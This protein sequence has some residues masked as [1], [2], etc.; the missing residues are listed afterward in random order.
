MKGER[1][2][3][4]CRVPSRRLCKSNEEEEATR[5]GGIEKERKIIFERA[6]SIPK[7]L[8]GQRCN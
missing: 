2:K 7:D 5:E 4:R 1:V 8:E 6:D 3:A